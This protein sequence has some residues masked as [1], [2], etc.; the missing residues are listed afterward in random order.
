ML[1][2]PKITILL[3]LCNILLSELSDE[4]DF[5]QEGNHESLLQMDSMGMVQN[6]QNFP[7]SKFVML[8]LKFIFCMQSF[9]KV[10]FTTLGITVFYKV[11]IISVNG[12][13]QVFSNFSK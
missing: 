2:L 10:N 12:R 5:L 9:L 13:D 7:Q 1:K 11:D 3:F 8:K 4:V 6:S